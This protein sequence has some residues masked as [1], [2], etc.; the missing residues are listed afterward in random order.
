MPEVACVFQRHIREGKLPIAA[1]AECRTRFQEDV[2][3]GVWVLFPVSER[4]LFRVEA[5]IAG[6]P[7][8]AYLRAGDAIHLV[9]ARDAGFR[10]IWSSD[11]RL[12]AAAQHFALEGK[13]V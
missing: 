12:L 1:A 10:E 5:L 7:P 6:L 13:S 11:R 2:R 3:N 8:I 9:S 4:L